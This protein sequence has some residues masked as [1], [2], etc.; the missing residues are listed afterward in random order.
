MQ[1]IPTAYLAV[2]DKPF[3]YDLLFVVPVRFSGQEKP[4][5]AEES[6]AITNEN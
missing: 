2:T 5:F 3:F 4:R 1:F 6:G